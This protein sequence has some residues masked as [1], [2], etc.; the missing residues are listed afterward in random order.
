MTSCCALSHQSCPTT[1]FSL[2]R[3]VSSLQCIIPPST[4]ASSQH[5][6]PAG[7]ASRDGGVVAPRVSCC[8]GSVG[9]RAQA[10]R[11]RQ[12]RCRRSALS[13]CWIVCYGCSRCC[14]AAIAGGISN[15]QSLVEL[16]WDSR[17]TP[18]ATGLQIMRHV[19][20]RCVS[21]QRRSDT[22][23]KAQP[24]SDGGTPLAPV[25]LQPAAGPVPF[26]NAGEQS[27]RH[28][29]LR[30]GACLR[31]AM[32][33]CGLKASA[34][35]MLQLG[36]LVTTTRWPPE[37]PMCVQRNM[38]WQTGSAETTAQ[39]QSA[40]SGSAA[41]QLSIS[42]VSGAALLL[43]HALAGRCDRTRGKPRGRSSSAVR[44]R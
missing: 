43:R 8:H 4:F 32:L 33:M 28:D 29:V 26:A 35:P 16:G 12:P 38:C 17:C 30:H 11:S 31:A 44:A 27:G 5:D 23:T 7:Q 39:A 9:R 13:S 41:L 18:S 40:G 21:P 42:T 2:P 36:G 22:V 25:S 24:E 15:S 14:F 20:C 10:R 19:A 6:A 3:F 37:L 1:L 34:K